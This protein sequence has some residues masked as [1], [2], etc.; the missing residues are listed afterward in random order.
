MS[1]A[2]ILDEHSLRALPGIEAALARA[3]ALVMRSF[4]NTPSPQL[5][6]RHAGVG[7]VGGAD[8]AGLVARLE[9]A[10]TALAGVRAPVIGVLPPGLAP[11]RDL[12][13]PGVVDLLPAGAGGAAERI[14]LM[15]RVPVVTGRP[16]GAR[17]AP[18][19]AVC[20]GP[21]GRQGQ[22]EPAAHL[23]VVASSTGGVWVLGA[24]L[25]DLPGEARAVA[26]AQHMDAEFVSFFADWLGVVSGWRVC[27][28]EEAAPLA[29]GTALLAAG[30]KDLVVERGR[31]RAVP[32]RSPFVPC[33]DRLLAS[34]AALGPAVVAVVLSGMGSDGAAGLAEI[35]RAGGRGLCQEPATA[36]VPSMPE[37]ARRAA[38]GIRAAA[39]EALAGA[40][41]ALGR[42]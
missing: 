25:R 32:A 40:I 37:S 14:L 38:A 20:G 27:V 11:T 31:A 3:G 6:R 35:L 1:T 36:V 42:R 18:Q 41:A 23:V 17:P 7:V 26:I 24:M 12:L 33:A 28:V 16:G 4:G 19:K 5:L 10:T 34:A 21:D 13:G 30:G 2:V 22:A 9:R 39:P 8:K 29:P 15:A